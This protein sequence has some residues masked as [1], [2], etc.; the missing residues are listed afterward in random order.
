MKNIST[1]NQIVNFGLI[2]SFFGVSFSL[3]Q[4]F[5]GTHYEND[6]ISLVIS[7][8]ILFSGITACILNFKKK[9][10]GIIKLNTILKLGT[11]V[12]S[13]YV[14]VSIIYFLLLINIF[15][16]TYWDTVWQMS[17][18]T[19]IA[20]N[21]EQM[22]N[23]QTNSYWTFEEFRSYIEWTENIVYPFIIGVNLFI[24]FMFSLVIG[25]FVQKSEK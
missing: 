8:I 10:N 20:E 22:T 25:V 24:G 18:E 5:L 3:M 11:G 13:V 21:P 2:T 15:E 7:F 6:P 19:A 16:P 4:F 1:R 12:S 9:N 14:V 17:Y 23:P